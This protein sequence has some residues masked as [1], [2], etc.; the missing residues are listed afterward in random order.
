M[1]PRK[2]TSTRFSN[3]MVAFVDVLSQKDALRELRQIPDTAEA[4]RAF[5]EA[6]RKTFG[7]IRGFRNVFRSYIETKQSLK[8]TWLVDPPPGLS[9]EALALVRH[10]RQSE[11]R[12]Q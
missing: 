3:Y 7:D 6:A 2:K 9:T 11:P 10:M 5:M 12:T 8:D 1:P 4:Q